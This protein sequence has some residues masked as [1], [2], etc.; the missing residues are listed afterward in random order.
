MRQVSTDREALSAKKAVLLSQQK[1]AY[2]QV[3]TD[4]YGGKEI[5][6]EV[7]DEYF[8]MEK[9]KQE[10]PDWYIELLNAWDVYYAAA[11]K[12]TQ[13]QKYQEICKAIDSHDLATV[14]EMTQRSKMANLDKTRSK[15][16]TP[17]KYDPLWLPT[18]WAVIRH[19]K[20]QN[21]IDRITR[22]LGGG[23][24]EALYET[25]TQLWG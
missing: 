1:E 2:N 6:R 20:F 15:T 17:S 19:L 10:R 24:D 4:K 11:R 7:I 23:E 14:Q 12:S 21:A 22:A 16:T 5:A 25:A 13:A 9:L 8:R 3:R 18:S